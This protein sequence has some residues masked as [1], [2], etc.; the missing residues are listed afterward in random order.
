MIRRLAS[1]SHLAIVGMSVVLPGGGDLAEFGRRVYRSLPRDDQDQFDQELTLEAAAAR[2]VQQVFEQARLADRQ[3][4]LVNLSP[5]FAKPFQ[6][7]ET[8]SHTRDVSDICTALL[9]ASDWLESSGEEF[10]LLF[11]ASRAPQLVCTLLLA[12]YRSALDNFRPV[13][14]HLIGAAQAE[15]PFTSSA[16][17]GGLQE[18]LRE[19]GIGSE[20]I[21]LLLTTLLELTASPPEQLNGYLEAF[22]LR[23][24]LTCA[25]ARAH[26]GLLGL[27]ETAWCLS[28]HVIP[29]TPDW[30]GPAQPERWQS[31]PFYVPA[32]SRTWFMPALQVSRY[33]G[34]D[35]RS[36]SGSFTQLFL[37][38]VPLPVCLPAEAP[39][40]EAYRLLPLAAGSVDQLLEKV[41]ALRSDLGASASLP[42]IAQASYRQY[43]LDRPAARCVACLVGHTPQEFLRELEFALKGIADAVDR[44]V[45]WQT[46]LGSSFSPSPVGKDGQISFVYPGAF[47][48]FPGV[49]RDLFYLYPNLF[50]HLSALTGDLGGL[51]NERRLYPRSLVPLTP[52]DLAAIEA[53]LTADPIAMVISGSCLAVLFT[54]LLRNVFEIHP[55]SAFGYSLGEISMMYA[56]RVWTTADNASE[57]LRESPLFHTRLS[58]PQNAVREFWNLPRL[59]ESSPD[60]PLWANYL[61]MV[62]P[63]KVREVLPEE[64]HVYLTHINTPRQVVIGGDP[65][66]CRR[67]IDRL[68]CKS[69]QAPFD[70]A[71]H[72]EPIRSELEMLTELHSN[73]IMGHPDM[74]L[75]SAATY[76]PMPIERQTIARQ[77]ALAICTTLDF[78][79]L[80]QLA[81]EDGARI[82]IELGPGSN[83]ARWINETLQGQPHAS[84]SINRKGV[85]DHL[86]ILRLLAHLVAQH[87]PVNLNVLYQ[88]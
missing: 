49:G 52:V 47:N 28:R 43:L 83:C 72:S 48:S 57:A 46:P 76:R 51:L 82:F 80:I 21:G 50:N 25:I 33:A 13:V 62:G 56:S 35:L 22:E 16:V 81:Y 69:I 18:A 17:S 77:I 45:D 63:E 59:A 23:D 88:D 85:D 14:A 26:P 58:G 7:S 64:P 74:T 19:A 12:E 61:L 44:Q 2:S 3:V 24:S 67:I 32:E 1:L 11:E 30:T 38:D 4:P 41:S 79:R 54:D 31:S 73:P 37:R 34:L 15:A 8:I 60:Q 78:P 68:K 27:V 66:A 5:G 10:V 55:A 65:A 20:S 39:A 40:R 87:V 71:I 6:H 70:Y 53:Q 86:S 29:G 75:Y 9:V 84:Y 36:A 42:A